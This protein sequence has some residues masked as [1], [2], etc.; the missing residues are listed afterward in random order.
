[1]TKLTTCLETDVAY[2]HARKRAE[3]TT[4]KNEAPERAR[5]VPSLVDVDDV[6]VAPDPVEVTD[7]DLLVDN[8]PEGT[9][10][11]PDPVTV[12]RPAKA[13]ELVSGV[14]LDEDGTRAVYGI[15]EMTPRLSGG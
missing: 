7:L 1:L 12:G 3:K 9:E 5:I 14:Q 10:E 4:P 13:T 2:A 6:G 8:D 15:V 11:E